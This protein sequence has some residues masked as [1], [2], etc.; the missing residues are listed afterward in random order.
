MN[1]AWLTGFLVALAP[2]V[3][4]VLFL[5]CG[6]YPGLASIEKCRQVLVSVLAPGSAPSGDGSRSLQSLIPI[7]GG[8]L[9]AASLA[10]RGPPV[11]C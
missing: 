5:L 2:L 3:L 6:R 8:R 1:A 9:I 10:G 4:L 11:T 7:R